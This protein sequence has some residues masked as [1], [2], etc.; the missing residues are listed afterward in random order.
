[1]FQASTKVGAW[2]R[3]LHSHLGEA[4]KMEWAVRRSRAKLSGGGDRL[5]EV[6]NTYRRQQ[7]HLARLLVKV[8]ERGARTGN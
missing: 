7:E 8:G 2:W 4:V 6:W 1:M 3:W 5:G